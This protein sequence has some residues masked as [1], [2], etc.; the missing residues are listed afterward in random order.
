M[1]DNGFALDAIAAAIHA[2]TRIV[3]SPIG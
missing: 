3:C 2:D 1:R